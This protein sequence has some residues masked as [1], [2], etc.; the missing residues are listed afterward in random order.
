VLDLDSVRAL[1]TIAI[2]GPAGVSPDWVVQENIMTTALGLMS[3]SMNSSIDP[4]DEP[5]NHGFY[6]GKKAGSIVYGDW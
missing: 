6:F 5:S 3:S 1:Y 2:S 4:L